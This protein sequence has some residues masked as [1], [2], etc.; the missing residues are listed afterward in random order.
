MKPKVDFTNPFVKYI[1]QALEITEDPSQISSEQLAQIEGT[2]SSY[3]IS[4][5]FS[6]MHMAILRNALERR[7]QCNGIWPIIG[8]EKL[9][10]YIEEVVEEREA[11][12]GQ[13]SLKNMLKMDFRLS[14]RNMSVFKTSLMKINEEF[15]ENQEAIQFVTNLPLYELEQ[16][17][18]KQKN[19]ENYL[20]YEN[21]LRGA[22]QYYNL[23]QLGITDYLKSKECN[24]EVIKIAVKRK[25]A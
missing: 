11:N 14:E 20:N 9:K 5:N 1:A 6:K 12:D 10:E 17:L 4:Y 18:I 21:N 15:E 13:I 22:I 3:V 2:L 16:S 24:D 23:R 19:I 25:K 7:R 8:D